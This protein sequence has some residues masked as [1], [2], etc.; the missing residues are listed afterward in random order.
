MISAPHIKKTKKITSWSIS[1]SII[2]YILLLLVINTN[3]I[4]AQNKEKTTP[5]KKSITDLRDIKLEYDIPSDKAVEVAIIGAGVSG[6]YSAYRLTKDA[7]AALPPDQVQIFEMSDRIGGRLESVQLPG[8]TITGELGGMRYLTSQKIIT[9]LV[10][11]VFKEELEHVDFPMG[12]NADLFGYF[13]K[14]RIKMNA[15]EVAQEKGGSL[16]THYYLNEKDKGFSPN[17]LFNKI[18]YDVLIADPWFLMHFGQYIKKT[19]NYDYSF[20]IT[21]EQWNVI[22]PKLTYNFQGP[23][24]GMKVNDI[25]FWNLIKDQV[26]QEGY[27]FLSDTG[28]YYSNTINWNAAEAFPYMTGDFSNSVVTYRTIE[29]GYDLIAYALADAYLKEKGANIWMGNRLVTFDRQKT[30]NYKYSLKFFHEKSKTYWTL[31]TNNI[32]LAIPRRSLELLDQ[33]NFFFNEDTQKVFQKNIASVIKEPSLKIL[34]GFENPWWIEDFKTYSGHSITDLPIRQSY[35]FGVDKKDDSHSLFLGSYNDMVT[36]SFWQ[37]LA[38]PKRDEESKPSLFIPR[39]TKRVKKDDLNP[40]LFENQA[41]QVMV[42]EAMNQIRELH[43]R[44]DIPSPYVTWYK[45]WSQDPYGA[46]YHAWKAKYDI[47]K[48]MA[49]MRNPNPQENIYICGE[50]YSGQQGWVEG[51]FC[52]A[53]KMLEDFFGLKRPDWIP[54]DYYLGW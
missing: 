34:M 30:S 49:Y 20:K 43:N 36:V 33:N 41:P 53:E 7:Q 24:F 27:Q 19:S 35:Y 32:V 42:D 1:I 39:T 37:A 16:E 29:G 50:S 52:V 28:G 13:R 23:Y 26:S 54:S 38:K 11:N 25:G 47:A 10:Q 21:R 14:Q 2:A 46:G 22:K 12:N 4:T 6:L 48:T 31:K 51:A 3:K 45:D 15:W 8:M 9:S 44:E 40:R 18:I 5:F 17:Q